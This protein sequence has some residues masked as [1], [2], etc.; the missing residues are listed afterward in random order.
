MLLNIESYGM[1]FYVVEYVAS[2]VSEDN[3]DFYILGQAVQKNKSPNDSPV[4]N[5]KGSMFGLFLN[6]A[7][8]CAVRNISTSRELNTGHLFARRLFLL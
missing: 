2:D 8:T 6:E 7:V 3:I 4:T 1:V 5:Q